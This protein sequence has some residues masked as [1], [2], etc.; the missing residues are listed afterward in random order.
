MLRRGGY[1]FHTSAEKEVV[2]TI[3]EQCC[4]VALDARKEEELAETADRA[5][6]TQCTFRLPD[7]QTISIGPERFRAP[8]ALFDPALIGDECLG[9]HE[10]LYHSIARSDLDLRARLYSSVVLSGGSTLFPGFGQ[11]LLDE[12]RNLAPKNIKIRIN[13]SPDRLYR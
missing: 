10:T 8:E 13:A 7:G 4:Y 5:N 11:R 9:V 12:A 3:K 1:D 6:S 2:R